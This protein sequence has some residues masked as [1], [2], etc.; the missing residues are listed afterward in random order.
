VPRG[1]ASVERRA[2]RERL[3][4]GLNDDRSLTNEDQCQY[5]HDRVNDAITQF[6]SKERSWLFLA[7]LSI[8]LFKTHRSLPRLPNFTCQAQ[9]SVRTRFYR[10]I[11]VGL[12]QFFAFLK[13]G[14]SGRTRTATPVKA[15]DFESIV[16]TNSTTLA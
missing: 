9:Y 2:E 10:Q 12:Q 1:D 11:L 3:I 8:F 7:T 16:S 14:T 6:Q 4:Q 15:M 5:D 13:S